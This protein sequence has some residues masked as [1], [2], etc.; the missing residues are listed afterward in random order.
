LARAR[1]RGG[2]GRRARR[3]RR[4]RRLRPL[5]Q[6]EIE[7]EFFDTFDYTTNRA[8]WTEDHRDAYDLDVWPPVQGES[9]TAAETIG[10]ASWSRCG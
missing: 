5:D 10:A 8:A 1:D 9:A 4:D 7:Q 6:S 3:R 2:L